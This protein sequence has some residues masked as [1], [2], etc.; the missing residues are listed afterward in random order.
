MWKCSRGLFGEVGKVEL[1]PSQACNMIPLLLQSQSN[2]CG[3][4]KVLGILPVLQNTSKTII[5]FG[6]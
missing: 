5:S 2:L 1:V 3:A 6:I 4:Q